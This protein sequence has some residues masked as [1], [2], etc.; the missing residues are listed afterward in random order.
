MWKII[1]WQAVNTEYRIESH[2]I[3][4]GLDRLSKI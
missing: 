4:T 2:K 1:I 3:N